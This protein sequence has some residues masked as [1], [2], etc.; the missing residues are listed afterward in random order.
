MTSNSLGKIGMALGLTSILVVSLLAGCGGSTTITAI[1]TK[2]VTSG[3]GSVST[4]TATTTTTV[5][6]GSTVTVTGGGSATTVTQ[7]TT[8]TTTVSTPGGTG[9][10]MGNLVVYGDMVSNVGCLSS[11]V[12]H[13]GELVVFRIRIVDPKTG[14]DMTATEIPAVGAVQVWLPDGQKFN[15]RYGGHGGTP[16]TDSFWAAIWEIPLNYPL[17]SLGYEAKVTAPDGRTG[18][19]KPFELL[20]SK[21][22][23][24]A[25]DANFVRAWSVNITATGFSV[26]TLSISQGAKVTFNNKDT[27]P[28]TVI[29]PDFNSGVIA[30]SGNYA[31]VFSTPGTFVVRDG[32]NPAFSVTITVNAVS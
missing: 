5:G 4:V 26:A 3:G 10:V 11:S 18:S 19:F 16:P 21:L 9:T 6:A 17:G 25:F 31:R 1:S 29:G 23:V 14:K 7:T 20:S 28:H 12:G 30:A 32:A 15:A 2:T 27:I 22:S 24:A 8:A 13:R